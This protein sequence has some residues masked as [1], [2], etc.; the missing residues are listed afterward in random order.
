MWSL[1]NILTCK[2]WLKHI[3]HSILYKLHPGIDN[4]YQNSIIVTSIQ[5]KPFK[6]KVWHD[7]PC[8]NHH[9]QNHLRIEKY[10]VQNMW[11]GIS[12]SHKYP[13]I[14]IVFFWQN[15]AKVCQ[16][17]LFSEFACMNCDILIIYDLYSML[18][19]TD[20]GLYT[21]TTGC[22]LRCPSWT[23]RHWH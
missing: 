3:W 9:P 6:W 15:K 14:I 12:R 20:C 22:H 4:C 21:S 8:T 13:P 10:C 23:F 2:I 1:A 17:L 16:F 19:S 18:S 5:A 7:D 11:G